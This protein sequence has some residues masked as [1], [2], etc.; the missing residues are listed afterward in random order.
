MQNVKKSLFCVLLA[1]IAGP[2]FGQGTGPLH[3]VPIAISGLCE[4]FR[5]VMEMIGL[6]KSLPSFDTLEEALVHF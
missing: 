5:T 4:N 2:A 6:P 3:G 1:G